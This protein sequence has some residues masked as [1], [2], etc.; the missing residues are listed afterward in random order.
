MT[1][2]SLTRAQRGM[3]IERR[4]YRQWTAAVS[5]ICIPSQTKA[6]TSYTTTVDG[7][8]CPDF[9]YRV[10]RPGGPTMCKHQAAARIFMGRATYAV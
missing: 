1:T 7:C 6:D 3:Q 2:A 9:R 8:S 4:T 5:G 10:G